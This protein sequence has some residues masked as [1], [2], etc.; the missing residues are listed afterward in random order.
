MKTGKL[1][2]ILLAIYLLL[3]LISCSDNKS[4]LNRPKGKIILSLYIN[5]EMNIASYRNMSVN[6]DSFRISV[7]NSLGKEVTSF[8]KFSDIKE[9]IELDTGSYYITAES[10]AQYSAAFDKPFYSGKSSTFHLTTALVIPIQITCSLNNFMITVDYTDYIKN[11]CDS[12]ETL[13]YNENDTLKFEKGETRPG[14]FKV[15][16]VNILSYLYYTKSD[17]SKDTIK[18]TGL[19]SDPQPRTHYNITI[20]SHINGFFSPIQIN[21][22]E[23]TNEVNL[24][25]SNINLNE[26]LLASYPLQGNADDIING[27][28]GNPINC[29]QENG[30]DGTA[31]S[32]FFFPNDAI[33][34]VP[35]LPLDIN[36]DFSIAYWVYMVSFS[37]T[38]MYQSTVSCRHNIYTGDEVG[39][40][41]MVV[42]SDGSISANFHRNPLG[43]M[44]Q[45][46]SFEKLDLAEWHLIGIVRS[47]NQIS[48]Y[49]DNKLDISQSVSGLTFYNNDTWTFGATQNP[50]EIIRELD[51]YL[52][53]V[54]F[55][56]R[57]LSINEIDYL[58]QNRI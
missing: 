20:D 30:V 22:D 15:G 2:T 28:N 1:S 34:D 9:E 31:N 50:G 51:G 21:I 53:Q 26:G 29:V 13:I 36:K 11:H 40:L 8:E 42:D 25:F 19:I 43:I 24:S 57:S 52:D 48:L 7:F 3:C 47:D 41:E 6:T 4:M 39:G 23:T 27:Y 37:G 17:L 38:G 5:S 32:S 45:L 33:I 44:V 58:Y 55:Y 18:I 54:R 16:P 35:E 56:Q 46:N 12:W 14:Y 10:P 49:I